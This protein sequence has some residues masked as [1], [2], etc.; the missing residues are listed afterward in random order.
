M[1]HLTARLAEQHTAL[2]RQLGRR[3]RRIWLPVGSGTLARAFRAATSGDCELIGVDVRVLPPDDPRL[4]ALADDAGFEL[5]RAAEL[6][7]EPATV[8]AP[9]PSNA[10]YDAK[11]WAQI[12][13][14]GRDGDV[15]WNVA[16]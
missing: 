8:A 11:L 13:S 12:S 15:W 5:R 7:S 10:H 6:F 16:R 14:H 4:G 9:V 3:P 1:R 2:C